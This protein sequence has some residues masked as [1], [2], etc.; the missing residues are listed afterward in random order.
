MYLALPIE[1]HPVGIVFGRWD[2]VAY[3]V[4]SR[5]VKL[6]RCGR[7]S[8]ESITRGK[9]ESI[10]RRTTLWPQKDQSKVDWQEARSHSHASMGPY[11]QSVDRNRRQ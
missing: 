4:N 10:I 5:A 2:P 9:I 1:R 11:T 3:E 7:C 8:L 6:E